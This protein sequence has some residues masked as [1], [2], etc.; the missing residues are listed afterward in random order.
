MRKI[1]LLLIVGLSVHLPAEGRLVLRGTL[2][3]PLPEDCPDVPSDIVYDG[4]GENRNL[5]V[6]NEYERKIEVFDLRNK[7]SKVLELNPKPNYAISGIGVYG[8]SVFLYNYRSAT[9]YHYEKG[10]LVNQFVV[11]QDEIVH[12]R[13]MIQYPYVQTL[14]PI[15]VYGKTLIMTGFRPGES[16]RS[17]DIPDMVL[18]LLD[19][20]SG[21]TVN[22]VEMPEIYA[23]YNWGGGFAYRMPYFDLGPDGEVACCFAAS[24]TL[25]AYSLTT[26]RTRQVKAPSRYFGRIA[27]YSKNS[28]QAP[29]NDMPWYRNNPSYDGIL[30]DRW[31]DVYYRIA[32]QPERPER[33]GTAD[34]FRKPVSIIVLDKDLHPLE[35]VLLDEEVWF[36]PS[37]SF[38]SQDGLSIQVLTGDENHMTFYQYQYEKG[39]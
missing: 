37:C 21:K 35:E 20:K 11:K 36:R 25:T 24:E 5:Y 2:S 16:M 31:R 32:L 29:G 17:P 18:C 22:V 26:G 19:L 10:N 13:R 33:R 23:K 7:T 6:L 8:T 38:V 4:S 39:V 14:S 3:L 15:K 34:Y 28:R 1:I 30:Y 9:V 27:P 12:G